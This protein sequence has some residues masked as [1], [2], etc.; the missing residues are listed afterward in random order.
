MAKV[1]SA[2]QCYTTVTGTYAY[3]QD[4]CCADAILE[5][6]RSLEQELR[7]PLI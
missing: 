6:D 5:E 2:I 1:H 4:L 3:I 7:Q